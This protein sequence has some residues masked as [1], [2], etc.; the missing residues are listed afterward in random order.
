MPHRFLFQWA[1]ARSGW[2]GPMLLVRA[3]APVEVLA[4]VDVSASGPV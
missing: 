2:L 4:Q 3:R 1:F